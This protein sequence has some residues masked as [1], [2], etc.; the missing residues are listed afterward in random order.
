MPMLTLTE[1]N[2]PKILELLHAGKPAKIDAR[3][4][5]LQVKAAG[6]NS[7]K[8]SKVN[9]VNAKLNGLSI[10][11]NA[12]IPASELQRRTKEIEH[13]SWP[14]WYAGW[15]L[16]KWPTKDVGLNADGIFEDKGLASTMSDLGANLPMVGAPISRNLAWRAW[17][18]MRSETAP[19]LKKFKDAC[20]LPQQRL[21]PSS[22]FRSCARKGHTSRIS[23]AAQTA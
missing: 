20:K 7:E 8:L 18:K 22:R 1:E 16:E 11:D 2:V 23:L 14:D 12:V 17:K 4:Y 19:K 10:G 5:V 3:E 15:G 21:E 9:N 13:G 6:L